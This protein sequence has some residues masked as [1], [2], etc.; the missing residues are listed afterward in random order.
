MFEN[1]K[2]LATIKAS[3]VE[4]PARVALGWSPES[5]DILGRDLP[6]GPWRETQTTSSATHKVAARECI[7]KLWGCDAVWDLRWA[8]PPSPRIELVQ[9]HDGSGWDFGY[10]HGDGGGYF[11]TW[12]ATLENTLAS[13]EADE[14]DGDG[15]LVRS[16]VVALLRDHLPRTSRGRKFW[17]RF[18]G[19][20]SAKVGLFELAEVIASLADA[21]EHPETYR[22]SDLYGAA[23][24]A[25]E[26]SLA[27]TRLEGRETNLRVIER[28]TDERNA[29]RADR[30]LL[31]RLAAQL[32]AD[33]YKHRPKG[34]GLGVIRKLLK[35]LLDDHANWCDEIRDWLAWEYTVGEATSKPS[36]GEKQDDRKP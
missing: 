4:T 3:G 34:Q 5:D 25:L 9:G 31:V 22:G 10:V 11:F 21:A 15:D 32:L 30:E 7:R 36:G 17:G 19:K 6:D 35:R 14:A 26:A 29:A 16:E 33:K 13:V 12:H 23:A 2:V 8:E 18:S 28:L 27:T 24:R 20:D 1:V